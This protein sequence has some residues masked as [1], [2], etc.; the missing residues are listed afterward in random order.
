MRLL[1]TMYGKG[2][3]MKNIPLPP[4]E[5]GTFSILSFSGSVTRPMAKRLVMLALEEDD[6]DELT[7]TATKTHND[8]AKSLH[9]A[10]CSGFNSTPGIPEGERTFDPQEEYIED[11]VEN[12]L[13][14]QSADRFHVYINADSKQDD[15][16]II[17]TTQEGVITGG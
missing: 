9:F 12:W 10:C 17:I 7:E 11:I 16:E 2:E 3:T 4:P 14:Q 1:T 8:G 5:F 15:V 6:T 13:N